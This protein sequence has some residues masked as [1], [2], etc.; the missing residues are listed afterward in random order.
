MGPRVGLDGCG[1]S[2]LH[3]DS[4][5]GPSSPQRVAIPTEL[6]RP[7]HSVSGYG[8]DAKRF[9]GKHR[10]INRPNCVE[11]ILLVKEV[12]DLSPITADELH[13]ANKMAADHTKLYTVMRRLTASRQRRTMVSFDYNITIQYYNITLQYYNITIQYYNITIKYNITIQYYN[14]TLQYYN[15]TLQY[16]NITIKYYNITI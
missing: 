15:I 2:R 11:Q 13:S 8:N 4:I 12:V 1:K 5:L 14:I 3:R 16:Y 10:A 6:S 9:N 7:T